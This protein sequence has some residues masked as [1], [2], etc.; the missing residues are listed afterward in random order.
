MTMK[1]EINGIGKAAKTGYKHF[2]KFYGK[3][4]V[5]HGRG[6]WKDRVWYKRVEKS[7]IV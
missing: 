5:F 3:K 7:R 6:L 1:Y 2:G 4:E